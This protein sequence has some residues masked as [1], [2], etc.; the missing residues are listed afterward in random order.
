MARNITLRARAFRRS[1]LL[2]PLLLLAS[3]FRSVG[4]TIEPTSG[5]N[6]AVSTGQPAEPTLA[7]PTLSLSAATNAEDTSSS[8]ATVSDTQAPPAFTNTPLPPTAAPITLVIVT[9]TPQFITPMLP[10]GLLTP[11]TPAPTVPGATAS[12]ATL[13]APNVGGTTSTPSG[14]ITPT[15]LPGVDDDCIYIVQGG[16]SLYAIALVNSVS[17]ED[18]LAVNPD[19][20]GD[21]PVIYPEDQLRLPIEG[22]VDAPADTS[23]SGVPVATLNMSA[24]GGTRPPVPTRPPTATPTI[25]PDGQIYIVQS[26]DSLYTIALEFGTTVDAIIEAND[27]ANP[28]SLD[29]GDE[30]VIPPSS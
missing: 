12:G 11:D 2:L 22:C 23:S 1:V 10:M 3:C 15:S 29:V 9:S 17:V 13:I 26:G 4:D 7:P 27:L 30:L 20:E 18:I 6:V 28:D 14:L 19:L 5:A 16:D 25:S 21:P 24:A 8:A